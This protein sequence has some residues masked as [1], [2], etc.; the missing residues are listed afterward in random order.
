MEPRARFRSLASLA[1]IALFTAQSVFP[2][3]AVPRS[4]PSPQASLSN[5]LLYFHQPTLSDFDGDHNLDTAELFSNGSFK[6]VQINLGGRRLDLH[7]DSK[8]IARGLLFAEDVDRDNDP[9]LVWVLPNQ[10]RSAVV[11]LGDGR[12]H[13]EI[14]KDPESY[15][16]TLPTSLAQTNVPEISPGQANKQPVLMPLSILSGRGVKKQLI[17]SRPAS[18]MTGIAGHITCKLADALTYIHRRPPPLG[19]VANQDL[20]RS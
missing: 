14:A 9:D 5:L 16:T 10:P 12:G 15:D 11:W 20:A 19:F 3:S 2:S 4:K 7:F 18:S 8:T 1:L 13:F 6:S 17:L